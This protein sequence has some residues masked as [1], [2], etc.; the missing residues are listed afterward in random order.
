MDIVVQDLLLIEQLDLDQRVLLS[1]SVDV[2]AVV[3]GPELGQQGSVIVCI[4][5]ARKS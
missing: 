3:V 1:S 2:V 5:F 4:I